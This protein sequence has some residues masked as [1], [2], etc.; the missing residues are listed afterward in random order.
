LHSPQ[1]DFTLVQFL[2]RASFSPDYFSGYSYNTLLDR[3][4]Q[5]RNPTSKRF[6]VMKAASATLRDETLRR[7]ELPLPHLFREGA[8]KTIIHNLWQI[9]KGMNREQELLRQFFSNELN[10]QCTLAPVAN[11]SSNYKMVIWTRIQPSQV[12]TLLNKFLSEFVESPGMPGTFDTR[13]E[14]DAA[15][16]LHMVVCNKTGSKRCVRLSKP[17]KKCRS[18]L[19]GG[20]GG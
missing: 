5:Q 8:K 2:I 12:E 11:G 14:R 16:G 19:G 1:A 3:V 13:F 4:F 15:T 18:N 20:E 10:A 9:A 17:N 6:E 7:L